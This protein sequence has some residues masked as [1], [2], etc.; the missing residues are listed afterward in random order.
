MRI[1]GVL[2][3]S[4]LLRASYPIGVIGSVREKEG[5]MGRGEEGDE[6]ERGKGGGAYPALKF[7]FLIMNSRTCSSV[8]PSVL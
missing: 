8:M 5:G 4:M 3:H 6:W 7:H 1:L 2:A